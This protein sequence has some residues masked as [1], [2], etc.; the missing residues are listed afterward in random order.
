MCTKLPL[1]SQKVRLP[2][3]ASLYPSLQTTK[4]DSPLSKAAVQLPTFPFNGAFEASHVT[5]VALASRKKDESNSTCTSTI[6][7]K[8]T[9]KIVF[10]FRSLSVV[11]SLLIKR[12]IRTTLSFYS[13]F[14]NPLI[15]KKMKM[16]MIM[17]MNS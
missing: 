10:L 5:V 9:T 15:Q 1:S 7:N 14:S 16:K 17:I 6:E 8:Y 4:H 2:L 3:F 13:S 12:L 11:R